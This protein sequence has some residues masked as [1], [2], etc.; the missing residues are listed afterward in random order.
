MFLYSLSDPDIQCPD[1]AIIGGGLAGTYAAWRLREL[2]KSV[3]LYEKSP[4]LGGRIYTYHVTG[5]G[6]NRPSELGASFFLPSLHPR[7][8]S[9]VED[10]G[11]E[12][13]SFV[14]GVSATSYAN[15]L[16]GEYIGSDVLCRHTC[17]YKLSDEENNK[18]PRDLLR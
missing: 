3:V 11:L 12:T 9:L 13:E 4:R 6:S 10:L 7:L 1:I 16:R 17:P 14:S 2:N 5:T 8:S 15:Y 18:S